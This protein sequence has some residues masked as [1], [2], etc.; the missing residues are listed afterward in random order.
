MI[1]MGNIGWALFVFSVQK[2]KKG[3]ASLNMIGFG[4]VTVISQEA[5]YN[6]HQSM[7]EVWHFN[8]LLFFFRSGTDEEY[9]EL[10]QLLQEASELLHEV[11]RQ[12]RKQMSGDGGLKPKNKAKQLRDAAMSTYSGASLDDSFGKFLSHFCR[13][14]K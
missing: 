5:D 1:D 11:E 13:S 6:C 12:Q 14:M 3:G 8:V 7:R 2:G 4:K 9:G 10:Q